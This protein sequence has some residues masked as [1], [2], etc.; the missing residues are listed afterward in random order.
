MLSEAELDF[1]DA[2][3]DYRHFSLFQQHLSRYAGS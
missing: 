3:I 1:P 2:H